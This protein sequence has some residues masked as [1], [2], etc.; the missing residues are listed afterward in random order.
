MS[1]ARRSVLVVEDNP[2]H[3]LLVK[4]ALA[5]VDPSLDVLVC[6]DG[7]EAV[8]LLSGAPPPNDGTL[9]SVPD[10]VLLDLSMPRLDGFGVLDWVGREAAFERIP[11][12]VLTSS[13]SPMD[14]AR[15][16]DLGASGFFTTPANLEELGE[17]IRSI[18]VQWLD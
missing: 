1:H 14:E 16:M 6:S 2:D 13:S 11:V 4:L 5:R 7:R 17:M 9:R 18:V 12:I 3:A 10:L 15:A 8:D